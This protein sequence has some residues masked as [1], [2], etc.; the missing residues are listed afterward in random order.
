M[1][2]I[3]H[4]A[5]YRD[6]LARLQEQFNATDNRQMEVTKFV[7]YA[8][9]KLQC[10]SKPHITLSQD[11]QKVQEFKSFG[12]IDPTTSQIWVYVKNRNLADLLRT[13]CH[14]LVHYKQLV[15]GRLTSKK[16]GQDGSPIE[17]EA[18]SLAGVIMREYGR[19]HPHIFE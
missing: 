6:I 17:N 12:Y 13:L 4:P 8:L 9:A 1:I 11:T 10:E 14:E 5:Y 7:E 15:D 18:N 2:N 16:A 3:H 19:S